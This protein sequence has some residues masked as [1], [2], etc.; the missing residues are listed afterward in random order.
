MAKKTEGLPKKLQDQLKNINPT[1]EHILK[2]VTFV[3]AEAGAAFVHGSIKEERWLEVEDVNYKI[4]AALI[5]TEYADFSQ[6]LRQEY[7]RE[8]RGETL[9]DIHDINEGKK[10]DS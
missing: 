3:S 2:V 4:E 8:Q 10:T 7:I 5:S 6:K 1:E 9:A